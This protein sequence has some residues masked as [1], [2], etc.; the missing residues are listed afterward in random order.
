ML[1]ENVL[2]LVMFLDM[3]QNNLIINIIFISYTIRLNTKT[4]MSH[5]S[6]ISLK[7]LGMMMAMM[8]AGAKN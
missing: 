6:Q 1:P 7:I 3:Y 5:F 8:E 2:D 4:I